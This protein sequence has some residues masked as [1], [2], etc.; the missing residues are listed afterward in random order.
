[1]SLTATT[2]SISNNFIRISQEEFHGT[3]LNEKLKQAA[4]IGFFYL[5]I[6]VNCKPLIKEAIYFA[7]SFYK[8]PAIKNLK[9]EGLSGYLSREKSQLESL[10]LKNNYWTEYLSPAISQLASNMN[11]LAIELLK[12]TLSLCEISD[13]EQGEASGYVT[14]GKGDV[15][16]TLNHYRSEK[17]TQGIHSHRDFGQ[18][19]VLFIDQLGLQAEV[20]RN[21]VDVVPLEDHFVINFGRA[22]ETAVNNPNQ[23]NAAWHRVQQVSKDRIS[24]GV[25]ADNN[26]ASMIY[27]KTNE[28]LK[29]TGEVFADY[30]QKCFAEG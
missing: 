8:D 18:I 19:T 29:S 28:G 2:S 14:E 15:Y 5:E 6:P 22:L 1:M 9:L 3:A 21:W 7:N 23:L 25:F 10:L 11:T 26:I 12:K 16:F 13:E 24:F 27:Q 17:I 30:L 4:Q 20:D